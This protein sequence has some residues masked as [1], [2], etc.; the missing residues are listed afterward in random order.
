MA[1]S[2]TQV[3]G[4]WHEFYAL[5]GSASATMVGLLFVAASVGSGV[6]SANRR[7]AL[8]VFLSSSVVH[9]SSTLAASLVTLS[10][11]PTAAVY[12]VLI[13][14]CGFFGIAFSGWAWRDIVRDGL[15]ASIDLEDRLWY[16]ILPLTAY[17]L[18]TAAG[19]TLLFRTDLGCAALALCMG[20]LLVI[21]VHN[22]WDITVWSITRRRERN[23]NNP[24]GGAKDTATTKAPAAEPQPR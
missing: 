13:I 12:S 9:F 15:N 5:L 23:P 1:G 18:E 8:R 2:V 24:D 3:V 4:P 6:F 20:F 17:L 10:P 22:A 16:V 14:V 21:G 11:L 19:L 7:A